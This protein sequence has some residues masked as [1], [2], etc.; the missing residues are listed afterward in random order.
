MFA[1]RNLCLTSPPR[2]D[3]WR[4]L[5]L[6][7]CA[8]AVCASAACT[9][10]L[11]AKFDD[12][13]LG[14][15]PTS[16]PAPT[17]PNDTFV[18]RTTFANPAVVANP[19]GGKWVRVTPTQAHLVSPDDRRMFLIANTEPIKS[20]AGPRL[21]GSLRVRLDGLGTLGIG[22]R[23]VQGG[24]PLD[25]LGA[26]EVSNF[27]PP[28]GGGVHAMRPFSGAMLSSFQSLPG[29]APLS[30]YTAGNVVEINWTI[31]QSTRTFSASVL[32]GPSVSGVFPATSGN[33]ATTP[34]TSLQ[35]VLW[36]Q[37]PTAGTVAFVDDMLV[38]EAN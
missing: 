34:M 27:L 11:D 10:R 35:V 3:R 25:Y 13:P 32:G 38:E 33:L 24:S 17:P 22:F 30:G 2:F 14:A 12:D 8:L 26:V 28:A 18:W 16:T 1:K 31:D 37:R 15:P 9:Q 4:S 23:P 36:L 21:R 7:V 6:A 29:N 20:A 19:A 5:R